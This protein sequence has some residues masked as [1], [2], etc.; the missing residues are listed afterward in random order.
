ML[1]D[2]RNRVWASAERVKLRRRND[3]DDENVSTNQPGQSQTGNLNPQTRRRDDGTDR[4]F[5][6]EPLPELEQQQPPTGFCTKLY[7]K[8]KGRTDKPSDHEQTESFFDDLEKTLGSQLRKQILSKDTRR[9]SQFD[10]DLNKAVRAL[11]HEKDWILAHTDKTN[12]WHP[13]TRV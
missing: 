4:D 13:V 3:G 5:W 7:D 11:N 9:I 8:L 12:Q 1:Q 2:F 10:K 6:M